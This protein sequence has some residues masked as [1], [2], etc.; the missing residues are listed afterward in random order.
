M[1]IHSETQLVEQFL[2]KHT[3]LEF[4]YK[5]VDG[6]AKVTGLQISNLNQYDKFIKKY[7]I[8]SK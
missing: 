6:R 1:K 2:C 5:E 7:K 8:R 3:G 4:C